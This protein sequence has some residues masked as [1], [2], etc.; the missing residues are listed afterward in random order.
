MLSHMKKKTLVESVYKISDQS[1]RMGYRLIGDNI[2][3]DN[4]ADIISEP[5]GWVVFKYQMMA[6]R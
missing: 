3:P 5:V 1:D 6:I 4:G 2:P